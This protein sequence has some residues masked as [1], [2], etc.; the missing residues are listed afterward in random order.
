M[1]GNVVQ[2]QE[3]PDQ[4]PVL[5]TKL[6]DT[7]LETWTEEREARVPTLVPQEHAWE[8]FWLYASSTKYWCP[9][10]C[11]VQAL[12]GTVEKEVLKAETLWNFDQGHAYHDLF[13]QKI[14]PSTAILLGGWQRQALSGVALAHGENAWVD[15]SAPYLPEWVSG[16]QDDGESRDIVVGW[17][18]MPPFQ[19]GARPWTY[20]EAKVRLP[21]YRAVVKV[22]G[23]LRWPDGLEIQELKSEKGAARDTLDPRVGGAPRVHH[24]EQVQVAMWATGI[25]RARIIYL[26]KD[27][28]SLSGALLEHEIQYD[29]MMVARLKKSAKQ[30]V[31]AV[32]L[33]DELKAANPSG[34]KPLFA[35]ENERNEW[36]DAHFDRLDECPMKSK[37][38]A[39]DC[40]GREICFPKGYRKKKSA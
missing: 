38:K 17:S 4:V 20:K 30:C 11:A 1:L 34:D 16:I 23:I 15:E 24:V 36:M 22:D 12:F 25:H 27:A 26:F 32:R 39:K 37:G 28:Y 18:K 2:I 7:I 9:R 10:L 33:C 5:S 29:E 8:E 21:E 40:P 13:Q 3:S 19:K 31:E 35:D 6:R 14:L